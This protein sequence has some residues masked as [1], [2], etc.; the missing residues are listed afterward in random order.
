MRLVKWLKDMDKWMLGY[1]CVQLFGRYYKIVQLIKEEEAIALLLKKQHPVNSKRW[2]KPHTSRQLG[3]IPMKTSRYG[4]S[5]FEHKNPKSTV[6]DS[7]SRAGFQ[8]VQGYL[9]HCITQA[10]E[11]TKGP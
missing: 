1:G 6:E 11:G 7:C 5:V 9:D 2:H 3:Y 4:S 8:C 10:R